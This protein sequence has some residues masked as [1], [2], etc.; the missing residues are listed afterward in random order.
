MMPHFMPTH[1]FSARWPALAICAASHGQR[2]AAAKARAAAIS[3]AA[4]DDSPAPMGT[5]PASTPSQPRIGRPDE[6]SAWATPLTYSHQPAL[7]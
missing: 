4:D 5:S 3:T 1:S 7:S 2:P 6:L